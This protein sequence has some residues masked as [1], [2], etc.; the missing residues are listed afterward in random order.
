M[1]FY[2]DLLAGDK[3]VQDLTDAELGK[4]RVLWFD[5][6]GKTCPTEEYFTKAKAEQTRRV[7]ERTSKIMKRIDKDF[8]NVKS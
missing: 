1:K 5:E 6:A 8:F 3:T 7:T 4:L 2:Q